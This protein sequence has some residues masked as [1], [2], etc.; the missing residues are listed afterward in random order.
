MLSGQ[1]A[2]I[3]RGEWNPDG[4]PLER[5]TQRNAVKFAPF[6]ILG[7]EDAYVARAG[8]PDEDVSFY[9]YHLIE[10]YNGSTHLAGAVGGVLAG[11]ANWNMHFLNCE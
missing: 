6:G 3:S 2:D 9:N 4:N 1:E 7:W 8:Q 10:M 11:P 5:V